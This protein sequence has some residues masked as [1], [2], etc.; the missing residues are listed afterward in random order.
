MKLKPQS[1]TP[2][3]LLAA[4]AISAAV[5]TA[6]TPV[7]VPLTSDGAAAGKTATEVLDAV[8]NK[9][10]ELDSL[11]CDLTQSV[12]MSGQELRAVGKYI[13]ATGNR[14]R[15]EYRLYSAQPVTTE[16]QE[17]QSDLNSS[18]PA[19][20][21]DQ[22]TGSLQQVNDGSVL[23][24]LW[25]NGDQKQLTR[26]NVR[27]ITEAAGEIP[28]YSAARSLQDLGVGGLQTLITQLQTG[29][30]FGQVLEQKAGETSLLVLSGRWTTKAKEEYFQLPADSTA[31]LPEYIPDYVR[32]YIDATAML[33]RRI[34]YLKK[35]PNPE[36]QQVRPMSTMDLRNIVLNGEINEAAFTF[37]QPEGETIPEV[38]LTA[39]TIESIKQI[40]APPTT[41]PESRE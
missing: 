19:E 38:D 35:H 13:Q 28:N 40:A 39:Q 18:R 27:Q 12:T 5:A 8:T 11:S 34:Q 15:L 1:L 14:M 22:V 33:P 9:L 10:N 30:E 17:A 2:L 41:E 26:R 37:R 36:R 3:A 32:I 4:L 6:R 24:S 25:I 23:W 7:N 20:R 31:A 16:T 21:D 29:M